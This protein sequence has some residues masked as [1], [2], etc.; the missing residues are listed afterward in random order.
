MCDVVS[1]KTNKKP[2]DWGVCTVCACLLVDGVEY[3]L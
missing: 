1:D 3:I 2:G